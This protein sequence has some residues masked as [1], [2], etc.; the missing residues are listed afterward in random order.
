[1][2]TVIVAS[3]ESIVSCNCCRFSGLPL[4]FNSYGSLTAPALNKYLYIPVSSLSDIT[5]TV[6]Y[7][8]SRIGSAVLCIDYLSTSAHSFGGVQE[9]SGP[10]IIA[11]SPYL[12]KQ[13]MT[14]LVGILALVVSVIRLLNI[15]FNISTV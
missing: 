5:V 11:N 3:L 13:E 7:S 9:E 6:W 2:T 14:A 10:P 1:V 12:D 8:G 15:R 4:G